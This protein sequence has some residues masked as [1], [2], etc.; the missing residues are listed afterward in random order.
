[1]GVVLAPETLKDFYSYVRT[2]EEELS[3]KDNDKN[4]KEL[5]K[6]NISLEGKR[7]KIEKEAVKM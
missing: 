2:A 5:R 4:L 1:M 6:R 3:A 7:L